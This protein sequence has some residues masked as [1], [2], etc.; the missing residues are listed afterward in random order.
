[1][2]ATEIELRGP[3]DREAGERIAQFLRENAA[4]GEVYREVAIF[5]NTDN[6]E[7][8]GSYASGAAR[9]QANQK[10]YPDGRV[11]QVAKMKVGKP[12]GTEREEHEMH[13]HGGG[14]RSFMEVLKRLGVTEGSFRAC[15][16]HDYDLGK[17]T[18]T[19]KLGHVV[20]DHYEAEISGGSA[21]ELVSFLTNIGLTVYGEDEFKNIVLESRSKAPYI[22]IEEGV[23]EFA[24]E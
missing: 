22:P 23:R 16:R 18:L 2:G 10:K 9:I 14:L 19:L 6:L 7:S 20:G 5:F 3:L 13:F 1:M 11:H 4:N 12:S 21:D 8:F 15:E 17:I 24:I